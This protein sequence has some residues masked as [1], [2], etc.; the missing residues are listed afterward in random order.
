MCRIIRS[1]SQ[2]CPLSLPQCSESRSCF[3]HHSL[4][5]L[6]RVDSSASPELV[7]LY[8]ESGPEAQEVMGTWPLFSH[9][10][11]KRFRPPLQATR[12]GTSPYLSA[13]PAE[14]G[15]SLR[16][17]FRLERF[18]HSLESAKSDMPATS[19]GDHRAVGRR[20]FHTRCSLFKMAGAVTSV[21]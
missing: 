3:S 12:T 15:C 9:V 1:A 8:G 4:R 6:E 20:V 10:Y 14:V 11:R 21:Y 5:P 17:Q 13:A 19:R 2:Q 16:R 7:W 18:Q